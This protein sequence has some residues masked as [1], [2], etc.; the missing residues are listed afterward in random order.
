MTN[1]DQVLIISKAIA[2]TIRYHAMNDLIAQG[3]ASAG[4]PVTK[5]PTATSQEVVNGNCCMGILKISHSHFICSSMY[6]NMTQCNGNMV[7]I[8][9]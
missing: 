1:T 4:F 7:K 6:L 3:F 5:E 9:C 8:P 2:T